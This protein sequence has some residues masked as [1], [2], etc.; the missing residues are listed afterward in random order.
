MVAGGLPCQTCTQGEVILLR[1]ARLIRV[2]RS[3]SMRTR[4]RV[5]SQRSQSQR[6]AAPT[7]IQEIS[8]PVIPEEPTR[9]TSSAIGADYPTGSEWL[10]GALALGRQ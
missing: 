8:A 3:R 9:L 4:V 7:A 1:C 2:R 5:C 10:R 6:A